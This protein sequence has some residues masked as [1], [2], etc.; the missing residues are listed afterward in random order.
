M[1]SRR[2]PGVCTLLV[3]EWERH[4]L[5][6]VER[7]VRDEQVHANVLRK[8]CPERKADVEP[9]HHGH[10][11]TMPRPSQLQENKWRFTKS[12]G[13]IGGGTYCQKADASQGPDEQNLEQ[14]ARAVS[15][16]SLWCCFS[17]TLAE[18]SV[19]DLDRSVS[20]AERKNTV[21]NVSVSS[22]FDDL[23]EDLASR[24]QRLP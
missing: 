12:L 8:S 13:D 17:Q 23:P 7:V 22:F 11:K 15:V 2:I 21:D 1:S 19:A 24:L 20:L 6:V 10:R 5:P 14:K 9:S 3:R 18:L 16:C 4:H